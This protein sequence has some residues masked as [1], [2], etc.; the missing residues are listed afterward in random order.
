MNIG[1]V[2]TWFE[3][4]AAYVSRQY[5]DV[6]QQHHEVFIYARGGELDAKRDPV[7]EDGHIYWG[8]R[9][10]SIKAAHLDLREFKH[11]LRIN[12]IDLVLFNE[13]VWWPPVL[14]ARKMGVHTAAYVD[15]YTEETLPFFGVY[16]LLICNTRRHYE[17]FQWHPNCCYIPWGTDLDLF[18]P[19]ND[20]N[21]T[22]SSPVFFHSAG[23]SPHRKGTHYLLR[24]FENVESTAQLVIHSQVD[25]E[26]AL[27]QERNLLQ[28][29]LKEQRLKVIQR[30]VPAPG[31]YHLGNV[32]VY[33]T[34]LEGVGLSVPE[35]I[36]CGLPAIVPDCQP[37]NEFVEQGIS[38]SLIRVEKYTA[39]SDGYYWPQCHINV[40]DLT[41]T[42]NQYASDATKIPLFRKTARAWAE[43]RL[44]WRKNASLLSETME[45]TPFLEPNIFNSAHYLLRRRDSLR[46]K[47]AL[48]SRLRKRWPVLRHLEMKIR[49]IL[50]NNQKI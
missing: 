13:Q 36:A 37:M 34:L 8:R 44:D 14:L 17:A 7:W 6:L 48:F 24:A 15:Y 21:S 19:S 10:W 39:R 41:D 49:K 45:N 9:T 4:G 27:P 50:E 2:T 32:Y 47:L 29:L 16:D 20:D 42:I 26:I 3:R 43:E 18:R 5:R 30:T 12:Q 28:F 11:W 22:T 35:A 46:N 40:A 38:G 1:I 33:P 25:L 23:M 31:L